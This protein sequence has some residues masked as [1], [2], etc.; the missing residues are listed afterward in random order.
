MRVGSGVGISVISA[1]KLKIGVFGCR[2]A[3]AKSI[4]CKSLGILI[5]HVYFSMFDKPMLLAQANRH[6]KQHNKKC[7]LQN[8]IVLF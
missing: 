5:N 3:K 7:M 2:F 4:V 6:S 1:N 8:C